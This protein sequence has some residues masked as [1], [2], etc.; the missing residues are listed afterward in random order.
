MIHLFGDGS[1]PTRIQYP[2][3]LR[4]KLLLCCADGLDWTDLGRTTKL[5]PFSVSPYFLVIISCFR[6][7]N[8]V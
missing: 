1:D 4:L 6:D 5:L 8:A 7:V 3:P 2:H